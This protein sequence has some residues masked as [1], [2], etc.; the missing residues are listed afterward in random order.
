MATRIFDFTKK[1]GIE[2]SGVVNTHPTGICLGQPF[3]FI[4]L[5]TSTKRIEIL[6]KLITMFNQS[7]FYHFLYS[8]EWIHF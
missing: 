7:E 2:A 1:G 5:K 8:L 4:V 3:F 6:S